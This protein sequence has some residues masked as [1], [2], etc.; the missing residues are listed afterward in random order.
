MFSPGD[1]KTPKGG[2]MGSKWDALESSAPASSSP[3]PEV[4]S[5]STQTAI[6]TTAPR[7]RWP[8]HPSGSA[9][10]PPT[11]AVGL[12]ASTPLVPQPNVDDSRQPRR[13]ALPSPRS[14]AT[15]T[16]PASLPDRFSYLSSDAP[17][18]AQGWPLDGSPIVVTSPYAAS[19]AAPQQTANIKSSEEGPPEFD[20]SPLGTRT[21]LRTLE[22][23]EQFE[24]EARKA[25]AMIDEAMADARAQN[26][27]N[28]PAAFLNSPRGP[29]NANRRWVQPAPPPAP[30]PSFGFQL[31]ST[32]GSD[33]RPPANAVTPPVVHRAP[34][35]RV[36][37]SV[38]HEDLHRMA[39]DVNRAERRQE[40][41]AETRRKEA[42]RADFDR[43]YMKYYKDPSLLS[44]L[45][46]EDRAFFTEV[47]TDRILGNVD[48]EVLEDKERKLRGDR[49]D[50]KRRVEAQKKKEEAAEEA[51]ENKKKDDKG[52][53]N[54]DEGEEGPR[55]Q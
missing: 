8:G 31:A 15:A 4:A 46:K 27:Y 10:P 51:E 32:V 36:M 33:N 48:R 55:S 49:E 54:D 50:L 34:G 43:N 16:G 41:T 14:G 20:L 5:A 6:S 44:T 9:A 26:R 7:P 40:D 19:A 37:G 35:D 18:D 11:P 23:A 30:I 22:E 53:K 42:L 47:E 2:L 28:R 38:T 12:P 17:R 13:P 1:D 21:V 45:S 39:V 25:G 29:A 52:Q 24:R 3:V